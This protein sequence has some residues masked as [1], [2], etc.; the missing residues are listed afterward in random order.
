MKTI[1]NHPYVSLLLFTLVLYLAGN[2]L[3][4][5]TDTAESNYALT[6]KEMVLSGNWISPQIYGRFWYDKPIFYYWELALSFTL[7]GFNEM[8]ARLPAALLGSASVLFTYWFARRTYGKDRLACR[9]HPGFLSGMLG[10]VQGSDYRLHP[11]PFH[12]RRHCL[13]LSGL[14]GKQEI[15]FPLLCV[16]CPGCPHQGTHRHPSARPC[17]LPLPSL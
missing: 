5:V 9:H 10:S 16:S 7:F 4:A 14:F 8:A 3:L 1:R 11:L 12:E 13:F 6:A 17:L 15:L 2:Q